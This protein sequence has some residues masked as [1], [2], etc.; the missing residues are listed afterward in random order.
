MFSYL[1]FTN[2]NYL[3]IEGSGGLVIRSRLWGRRVPG[4]EPHSTEDTSCMGLVLVKSYVVAKRP[5]VGVAWKFEEEVPAQMSSSLSDRGS[6]LRGSSQ[7]SPHIASKRDINIS[8]TKL[9][10]WQPVF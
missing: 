10:V 6:K 8:E 3:Q 4:P 5:P 1:V 7:Y 2:Q 9:F